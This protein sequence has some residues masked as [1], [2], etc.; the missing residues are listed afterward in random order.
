M[1]V[2]RGFRRTCCLVA[3][4]TIVTLIL[5]FSTG[6]QQS[7]GHSYLRMEI[8]GR[9]PVNFVSDPE[10]SK[11]WL[12]IQG[13]DA[14]SSGSS[15]NSAA[16]AGKNGWHRNEKGWTTL[17]AI[18]KSGHAGPGRM[19]FGVGDNGGLAPLLDAQKHGTLIASV[20]LDLFTEDGTAL[21]G[22]YQIKHI[23][24][25]SLE[26]VPASACGMYLTTISFR[27]IQRR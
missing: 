25:L 3:L 17:P 26:D 19:S 5:P 7:D 18:M 14:K 6:A 23:R 11:G 16:V 24:I 10:Y 1:G 4:F 22:K 13:V 8:A 21:I 9:R 20:E 15:A 27:S 12:A 2:V